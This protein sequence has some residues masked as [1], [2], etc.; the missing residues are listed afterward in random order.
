MT[1]KEAVEAIAAI[2]YEA[3]RFDRENETPEWQGGNSIAETEARAKAVAIIAHIRELKSRE[4]D[5]WWRDLDP[6]ESGDTPHEALRNLPDFTVSHLRSSYTGPDK[7]AV[8]VPV[9][10]DESDDDEVL[11]FDTEQEALDAS[12][13]RYAALAA[14]E[15]E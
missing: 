7:F 6:D 8:R 14:K 3:M 11:L 15:G 13:Q 10:D 4:P 5:W 9:L 12:K 2:I 1:D